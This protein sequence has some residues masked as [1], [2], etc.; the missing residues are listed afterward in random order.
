MADEVVVTQGSTD[1]RRFV[2][3]YGLN[4]TIVA[5]VS[6]NAGRY[7]EY[8]ERLIQEAAAF[9]PDLGQSTRPPATTPSPPRSRPSPN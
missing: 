1:D 9:P 7:L 3:A 2:A 8:Y 5:A 6:F 4:G